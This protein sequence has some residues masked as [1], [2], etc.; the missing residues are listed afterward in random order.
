MDT[1]KFCGSWRLFSSENFEAYLKELGINALFRKLAFLVTPTVTFSIGPFS[2]P[3][4]IIRCGDEVCSEWTMRYTNCQ[5]V[6]KYSVG[7]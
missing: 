2:K 3:G 1:N 4:D 6:N 7:F 5:S